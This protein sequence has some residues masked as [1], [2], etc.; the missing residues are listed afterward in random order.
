MLSGPPSFTSILPS[1]VKCLLRSPHRPSSSRKTRVICGRR[2]YTWGAQV[3]QSSFPPSCQ[4]SESFPSCLEF[5]V[6]VLSQFYRTLVSFERLLLW[7]NH[8]SYQFINI[9]ISLYFRIYNLYI[10]IIYKSNISNI[11]YSNQTSSEYYISMFIL[12]SFHVKIIPWIPGPVGLVRSMCGTV[13]D[14][15]SYLP[16]GLKMVMIVI[17]VII[18]VTLVI[19]IVA[20]IDSH[21]PLTILTGLY[22]SCYLFLVNP[23][24]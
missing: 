24:S 20:L 19:I 12:V 15:V 18:V 1:T 10:C 2:L 3:P 13:I 23:M 6:T 8:Q 21:R 4:S 7:K 11:Y 16:S 5:P 14:L 22:R 9:S 17:I